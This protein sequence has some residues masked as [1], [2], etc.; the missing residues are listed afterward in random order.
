[1]ILLVDVTIQTKRTVNTGCR[2]QTNSLSFSVRTYLIL[3]LSASKRGKHPK[4]HATSAALRETCETWRLSTVD[5]E[6]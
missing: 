2:I 3:E 1:M 4:I 6:R 5:F